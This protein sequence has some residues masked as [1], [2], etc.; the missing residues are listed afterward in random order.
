M[1]WKGVLIKQ[2]GCIFRVRKCKDE[3]RAAKTHAKLGS[4][5]RN[6]L[7]NLK[8]NRRKKGKAAMREQGGKEQNELSVS[9]LCRAS[10]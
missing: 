8:G 7:C 3:V 4:C 9:M 6:K 2:A 1:A 10:G 5:R